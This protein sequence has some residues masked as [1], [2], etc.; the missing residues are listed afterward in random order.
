MALFMF[1]WYSIWFVFP[2]LKNLTG[3]Y[4]W[5]WGDS[6]IYQGLALDKDFIGMQPHSFAE[7]GSGYQDLIVFTDRVP[8][9]SRVVVGYGPLF[10][11]Y[12]SDRSSGGLTPN[13]VSVLLEASRIEM[14]DFS[15]NKKL[16]ANLNRVFS[17]G[18]FDQPNFTGFYPNRVNFEKR[19]NYLNDLR[20][21][22]SKVDMTRVYPLKDS[23]LNM[24]IAQLESKE[25][26]FILIGFPVCMDQQQPKFDPIMAHY[27]QSLKSISVDFE[28]PMDTLKINFDHDPFYDAT[29]LQEKAARKVT[30]E[31]QNFII[32]N[33]RTRIILISLTY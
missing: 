26:D 22:V 23:V 10:Y 4:V 6:Q 29:H 31:L 9:K 32:Q 19:R 15:L 3:D 5:I 7:H 14:G 13:G 16:R 21:L 11:R 20:Q 1:V 12:R 27:S 2:T 25:T 28:L 33:P 17:L 30:S 24:A 18:A 8:S